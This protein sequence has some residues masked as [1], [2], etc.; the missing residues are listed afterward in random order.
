VRFE[1][2]LASVGSVTPPALLEAGFPQLDLVSGGFPP[3]TQQLELEVTRG[4]KIRGVFVPA[5][6]DDAPIVVHLLESLGSVTFG[7]K[8]LLGYPCLW[9]LRDAGFSSLMVDYRGI[10]ASDGRRSP[11]NM[12][13][14]AESIYAEALRRVNGD[15]SRIVI[16]AMSLGT[17][18]AASLYRDLSNLPGAIIMVAPVRAE[19]VAGNWL[20]KY[21]GPLV[22]KFAGMIN[23]RRPV[24]VDLVN[25][26]RNLKV[27]LMIYAP[28]TD[29][30]LPPKEMQMVKAACQQANGEW[31]SSNY[32]HSGHVLSAHEVIP[33]ELEFLKIQFPQT[34]LRK[35]STHSKAFNMWK[36]LLDYSQ[37]NRYP[38]EA[39]TAL[40]HLAENETPSQLLQLRCET[41]V[42]DEIDGISRATLLRAHGIPVRQVANTFQF[43]CLE[44]RDWV[45]LT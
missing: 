33:A 2:L 22:K 1:Q 15:S 40:W 3:D 23:V 43:F 18:A 14:D 39:L 34:V 7:T 24:K 41:Q 19:T 21:H 9:Q 28:E 42:A 45:D 20:G 37:L 12:P 35:N 27:P 5:K 8:D 30:A 11:R 26:M 10:G 36:R 17:L 16:R 44:E 13:L 32:N 6:N 25:V 38:Q 4:T 31:H 29:Y